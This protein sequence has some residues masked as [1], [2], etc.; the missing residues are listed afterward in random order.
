MA[1]FYENLRNAGISPTRGNIQKAKRIVHAAFGSEDTTSKQVKETAPL[2]EEIKQLSNGK[3]TVD[4]SIYNPTELQ[5]I[6][7]TVQKMQNYNNGVLFPG[8][9]VISNSDG[10]D[11]ETATG[12]FDYG[13]KLNMFGYAPFPNGYYGT[14]NNPYRIYIKNANMPELNDSIN[15]DSIESGWHPKTGDTNQSPDQTHELSHSAHKEALKKS[16][17]PTLWMS[18]EE[19]EAYKRLTDKFSSFRDL[20]QKLTDNYH[21]KNTKNAAASVSDYAKSEHDKDSSNKQFPFAEMFAEA[22]TDVLYNGDSARPFSK[23]I[24]EAY[25]DYLNEYNN[26]FGDEKERIRRQFNN[27]SFIDNLRSSKPRFSNSKY[28]IK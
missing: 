15:S 4:N 18:T 21:L 24:V 14:K 6:K 8:Y 19:D 22:Y 3:I 12:R 17:P 26:I 16:H 27:N 25:I 1:T 11:D 10:F 20:I 13:D 2:R 7:N 5:R 9:T 28:I 23:E